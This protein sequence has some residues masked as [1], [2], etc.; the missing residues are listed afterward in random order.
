VS[1]TGCPAL[2]YTSVS[3]C[4][5]VASGTS[6]Q[7]SRRTPLTASVYTSCSERTSCSEVA[8]FGSAT[9][10]RARNS[11]A[12]LRWVDEVLQPATAV[13]SRCGQRHWCCLDGRVRAGPSCCDTWRCA[14]PAVGRAAARAGDSR[15]LSRTRSSRKDAHLHRHRGHGGPRG[16]GD[17][18]T[19]SLPCASRR[20]A[21]APAVR[22]PGTPPGADPRKG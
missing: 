8:A 9:E 18:T 6:S 7:I 20:H 5:G 22:R 17:G 3:A 1:C 4:A 14:L 2:R 16:A 15:G 10:A 19:G 12:A 21:D 13:G 11:R